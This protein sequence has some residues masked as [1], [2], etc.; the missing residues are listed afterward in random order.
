VPR[1]PVSHCSLY[2]DWHHVAHVRNPQCFHRVASLDCSQKAQKGY[3][4]A[5]MT[6]IQRIGLVTMLLAI[7]GIVIAPHISVLVA[8]S[9]ESWVTVVAVV[10]LVPGALW[11]LVE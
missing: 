11:L 1:P 10:L 5:V 7:A 4:G 8:R 6:K 2:G 9:A 3:S